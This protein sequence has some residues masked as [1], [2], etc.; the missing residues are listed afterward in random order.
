[1]HNYIIGTAAQSMQFRFANKLHTY[2]A[3]K[4]DNAVRWSILME[5]LIFES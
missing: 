5:K 3:T 1:M 4:Y 2:L